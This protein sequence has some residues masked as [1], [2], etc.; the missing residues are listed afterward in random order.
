MSLTAAERPEQAVGQLDTAQPF[1]HM[2]AALGSLTWNNVYVVVVRFFSLT[3]YH[4]QAR[5]Y[6]LL[7]CNQR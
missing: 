3:V 4:L 1:A 6:T 7:V 5:S 2:V